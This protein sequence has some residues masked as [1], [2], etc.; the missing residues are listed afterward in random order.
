MDVCRQ[1]RLLLYYITNSHSWRSG[2]AEVRGNNR[3]MMKAR[4]HPIEWR[5]EC[6]CVWHVMVALETLQ[7]L[8]PVKGL[9]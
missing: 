9:L 5:C 8:V 6:V 2:I 3:L 7:L 1:T 4:W